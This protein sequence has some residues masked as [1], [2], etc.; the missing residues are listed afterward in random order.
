MSPDGASPT[1]TAS[2]TDSR[3]TV[4][5]RDGARRPKFAT[6]IHLP[7]SCA[8]PK[9]PNLDAAA[10]VRTA[11]AS[12]GPCRYTPTVN[13]F[14]TRTLTS[15]RVQRSGYHAGESY[16]CLDRL[17]R[18]VFTLPWDSPDAEPRRVAPAFGLARLRPS[19]QF[20]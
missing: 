10:V 15:D 11:G 6:C 13:L 4:K 8:P 3:S 9:Q 2:S 18:I 12:A 1:T 5:L 7:P 16:P 19:R 14:G 17:W 20:Q